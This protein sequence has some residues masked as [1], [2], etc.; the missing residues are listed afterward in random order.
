MT[1]IL[2]LKPEDAKKLH[3]TA[4]KWFNDQ[5]AMIEREVAQYKLA[6]PTRSQCLTLRWFV[7]SPIS[8]GAERETK[9]NG[10]VQPILDCD[11]ILLVMLIIM[12]V[13]MGKKT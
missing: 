9:Q 3:H 10:Y 4:V 13:T 1:A 7:H 12:Q 11:A 2:N 6:Q 8:V 5:S